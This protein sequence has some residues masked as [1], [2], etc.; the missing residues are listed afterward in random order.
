[1]EDVDPEVDVEEFVFAKKNDVSVKEFDTG[2]SNSEVGVEFGCKI[3]KVV[4]IISFS[5]GYYNS[6]V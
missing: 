3:S 1:V 5:G 4:S 2:N 6:K